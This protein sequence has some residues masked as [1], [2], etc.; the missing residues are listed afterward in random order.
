MKKQLIEKV[1]LPIKKAGYNAYFVGGCVRDYLSGLE[2]HDYDI[3]TTA[4]PKQL[5]SIFDK[6][7]NISKNSEVFGVSMPLVN[8]NGKLEEIEI[9]TLRRDLTKGRHPEIQYTSSLAEDAARRDFTINALYEDCDGNILDPTNFGLNDI[10]TKTLRFIGNPESRILEDP[11]RIFRY[12]RFLSEKG[13]NK[14]TV[15]FENGVPVNEANVI[16]NIVL[17][18]GTNFLYKEISKERQLKEI[19]KIFNG[20][21]LNKEILNLMFRFGIL[22]QIG[23][24]KYFIEMQNCEQSKTWHSEGNVLN[25]TMLVFEQ[26]ANMEHD[27]IDIIAAL[28]HDV[29]KPAAGATNGKKDGIPI[30]HNHDTIGAPIAYDI[31]KNMGLSNEDCNTIKWLVENHMLAHRISETKSKYKVWKLVSHPLFNRLLKLSIADSNGSISLKE[32]ETMDLC[33]FI[34]ESWVKDLVGK[35]MPKRLV[36]GDDFIQKGITPSQFFKKALE[37]AYKLQ[38]DQELSKD[39]IISNVLH[40]AKG[41]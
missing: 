28:L 36:N 29:G 31:C 1:L 34:K 2:P 39:V 11:L 7:S 25:H 17:K 18:H 26:A 3:C 14:A 27:Y 32:S 22:H 15:S 30:V 21:F 12:V 4:T 19:I 38:I 20:K 40:I 9:A 23:F 10:E 6:F 37:V 35:P 8:I 33:E 41:K 5:H 24:E 16:A 13:Y